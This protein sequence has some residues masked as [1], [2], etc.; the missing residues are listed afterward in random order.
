MAVPPLD[1]NI[2]AGVMR[3]MTRSYG[4]Q[5]RFFLTALLNFTVVEDVE[6]QISC[7]HDARHQYQYCTPMCRDKITSWFV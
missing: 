3:T 5:Q 6:F 4:P 7:Y 1:E 2:W